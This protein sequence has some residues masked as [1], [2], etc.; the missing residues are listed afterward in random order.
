LEKFA[1]EVALK[2]WQN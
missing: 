2:D 1:T